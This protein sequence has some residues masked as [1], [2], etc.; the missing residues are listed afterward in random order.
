[1]RDLVRACPSPIFVAGGARD[2]EDPESAF[3][4][5]S[6]AVSAGASGLVIGRNIYQS[7]DPRAA[8]DRVLSIVNG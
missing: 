3:R 6:D 4:M 8:L 7:P 5:A 1:M 2:G